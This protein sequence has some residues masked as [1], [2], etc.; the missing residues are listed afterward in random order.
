MAAQ[1][2]E[3]AR[4]LDRQLQSA[5]ARIEGFVSAQAAALARAQHEHEQVMRE[6]EAK[7]QRLRS[8]EIDADARRAALT[9]QYGGERRQ[10]AEKQAEVAALERARGSLPADVEAAQAREEA[11]QLQL[12]QTRAEFERRELEVR[13]ELQE[14]SRGLDCYQRLGLAFEKLADDRLRL[15]FTLIDPAQ[16]ARRF[17]FTVRMTEADAYDVDDCDPA[18][19]ALPGMLRQLNES[20]DISRFVQLMRREFKAYVASGR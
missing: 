2:E 10:L 9:D 18:V 15:V 6:V 5:Q 19:D 4:E 12:A 1:A 7:L 11:A 17:C 14:L 20:N 3:I 8:E 13:Y 16:P